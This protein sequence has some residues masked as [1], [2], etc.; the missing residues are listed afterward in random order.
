[1]P[2][3]E[4]FGSIPHEFTAYLLADRELSASR[5]PWAIGRMRELKLHMAN[6]P[7]STY[8]W[9]SWGWTSKRTGLL[10]EFSRFSHPAV[11]PVG[12]YGITDT[13]PH[14]PTNGIRRRIRRS[15]PRGYREAPAMGDR[16]L[17]LL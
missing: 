5:D 3:A 14:S 13:T 10:R 1:M 9:G 6:T 4:K 8:A 15:V 12:L 7:D 17:G 11:R 2:I 16:V